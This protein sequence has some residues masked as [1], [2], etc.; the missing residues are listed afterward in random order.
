LIAALVGGFLV[1][2]DLTAATNLANTMYS[3]ASFPVVFIAAAAGAGR[4]V[5]LNIYTQLSRLLARSAGPIIFGAMIGA[6]A[7][8][9][10][11]DYGHIW[12]RFWFDREHAQL[13]VIA[14]ALFGL[15]HGQSATNPSPQAKSSDRSCHTWEVRGHQRNRSR[16]PR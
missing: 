7:Y 3:T 8:Y 4:H 10:L 1:A 5:L 16:R 11:T 13:G 12:M 14:A 2:R 9:W 15:V 6:L